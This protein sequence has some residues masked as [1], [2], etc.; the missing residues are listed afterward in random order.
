MAF[1]LLAFSCKKDQPPV[2]VPEVWNYTV[3]REMNGV[4]NVTTVVFTSDRQ[5]LN[6]TRVFFG[7]DSKDLLNTTTWSGKMATFKV[8][9]V[10]RE[11]FSL[12]YRQDDDSVHPIK[13]KI[14]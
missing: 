14:K 10:E 9:T 13:I 6:G 8:T 7:D 11:E 5:V 4:L 2:K 3:A 1:V 12:V